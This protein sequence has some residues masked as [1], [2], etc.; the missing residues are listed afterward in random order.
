MVGGTARHLSPAGGSAAAANQHAAAGPAK[1]VNE[2]AEPTAHK[3]AKFLPLDY[4]RVG[5][6]PPTAARVTE[7]AT[8]PGN[9]KILG[10]Q[11]DRG[12]DTA[13]VRPVTLGIRPW[14]TTSLSAN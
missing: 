13:G 8:D 1:R 4:P 9:K 7:G 2:I 3:M 6:A 14:Q 10:Q 5:G 12:Y 11:G